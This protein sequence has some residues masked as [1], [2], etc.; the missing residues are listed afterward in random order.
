MEREKLFDIWFLF[1]IWAFKMIF[2]KKSNDAGCII[3]FEARGNVLNYG[4][5][6]CVTCILCADTLEKLNYT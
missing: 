2:G 1:R 3:R 6:I 4:Y 5:F